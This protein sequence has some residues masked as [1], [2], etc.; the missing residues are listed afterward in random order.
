[1]HAITGPSDF[2]H[3]FKKKILEITKNADLH[4]LAQQFYQSKMTVE[5]KELGHRETQLIQ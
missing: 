1:M 5:A 3:N 4:P 2:G